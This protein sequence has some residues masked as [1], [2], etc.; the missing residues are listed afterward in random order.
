MAEQLRLDW[1]KHTDCFYS[2]TVNLAPF[3]DFVVEI[4]D[5]SMTEWCV[6]QWFLYATVVKCAGEEKETL[7]CSLDEHPSQ[8]LDDIDQAKLAAQNMFNSLDSYI[9]FCLEEFENKIDKVK[10]KSVAAS[11]AKA[12]FLSAKSQS[13]LSQYH[14][15]D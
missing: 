10:K 12:L 8:V 9:Y 1:V 3:V 7:F 4:K 14:S 2:A 13:V 15:E 11:D 6:E 5:I